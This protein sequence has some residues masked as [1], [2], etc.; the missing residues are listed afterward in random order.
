MTPD[1]NLRT[2]INDSENAYRIY[3]CPE[4]FPV[5]DSPLNYFIDFSKSTLDKKGNPVF[6]DGISCPK[7]GI[8]HPYDTLK[9]I[10][11]RNL[12]DI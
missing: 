8:D 2:R 7:C 9:E 3:V 4:G 12:T 6:E 1:N 11:P 10:D 5:T